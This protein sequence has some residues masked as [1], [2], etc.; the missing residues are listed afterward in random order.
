[1][2]SCRVDRR[3]VVRVVPRSTPGEFVCNGFSAENSTLFDQARY[4]HCA[5][6]SRFLTTSPFWIA[7][8]RGPALDVNVVFHSEDKPR[9]EL[10]LR[11]W[12][13]SHGDR[14]STR[15]NSSP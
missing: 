11:V 6:I 7:A 13:G 15:L 10:A 5:F 1:M 9:K 8:A 4:R 3:S 12:V 14:K 2:G